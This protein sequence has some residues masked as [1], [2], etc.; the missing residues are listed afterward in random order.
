[1]RRLLTIA[2]ALAALALAPAAA[3]AKPHLAGTFNL[4]GQAGQMTRGP[5]GNIWVLINGGS[6]T[7]AKV[8]PNGD[9]TEY[10]PAAVVNPTGITAGYDDDLWLTRNNG[11]IHVPVNDPD[12]A[13]AT[14]ITLPGG[15][16]ITKGPGGKIWAAGGDQLVSF[17]PANPAGA[18]GDT[19]D[20]MGA[21][22]V[23]ASGGKIFVADFNGGRI[24]RSTAAGQVKKINVGGG[25]Q[26]VTSGPQGSVAY[27]NPGTDPQTVGRIAAGGSP[28]KT[29]FPL[30]TDPFGIDFAA[31]HN[32]WFAEFGKDRLGILSPGGNLKLFKDLPNN[33]GPRYLT[34][35]KNDTLW[36]GLEQAEKVARIKDVG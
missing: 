21:R 25:P 2:T 35:G 11:V 32:W 26:Q 28:Q 22:G 20:N 3:S 6:N 9:V 13:T 31:D 27:T 5:D 18:T 23:T 1:M 19:I 15:Q 12:S 17:D 8:K 30:G 36:V 4:S 33:S 10:S 34:A 7:L 29:R 16:G 14:D 24:I